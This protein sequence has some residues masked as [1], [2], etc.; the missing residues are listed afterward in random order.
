MTGNQTKHRENISGRRHML[1]FRQHNTRTRLTL[2]PERSTPSRHLKILHTTAPV[3]AIK[4]SYTLSPPRHRNNKRRR[5]WLAPGMKGSAGRTS[6]QRRTKLSA[7]LS[8]LTELWT[9][10]KGLANTTRPS[11]VK[12]VS[13][14]SMFAGDGGGASKAMPSFLHPGNQKQR[15]ID[16][17]QLEGDKKNM[18]YNC[19]RV[20]H[21]WLTHTNSFLPPQRPSHR[22]KTLVT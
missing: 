8:L 18:W 1:G 20:P 4:G 5:T 15:P 16:A 10:P 6:L 12:N 11:H 17:S 19:G 13:S 7:P 14:F 3:L 2:L 9:E 22:P 21:S